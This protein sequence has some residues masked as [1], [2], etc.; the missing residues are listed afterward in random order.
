MAEGPSHDPDDQR[1]DELA[2]V[3]LCLAGDGPAQRDFVRRYTSLVFSLCLRAGLPHEEAEDVCQEV[4]WKA[5]E[6]LPRYRG[7][8]RLA[9]WLYTVAQRRIVDYRRSPAR[10]HVPRGMPSD[11]GFPE[12]ASGGGAPSPEDEAAR[13]QQRRRVEQ[14]LQG[15]AEPMRSVLVAYYLGEVPVTEIGR[16]LGL[17]EGTVKTHL[18]RGRQALRETL[19]D[20]C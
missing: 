2:L 13:S 11:P 7:E 18:H 4:F 10:R 17:P 12:P 16:S 19:R 20:L 8:S 15:L 3:R 5:F 6:A 1:R 9:T 14:A